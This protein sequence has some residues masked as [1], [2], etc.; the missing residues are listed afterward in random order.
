MTMCGDVT[1]SPSLFPYASGYT[2]YAGNC[3]DNNPLGKDT[4]RNLFYPTAAPVPLTVSPGS[5]A[6]TTVPLYTLP[7]H[8]QNSTAVPV[9]NV[10][11]TVT[12]TST[13][14]SSAAA[15]NSLRCRRRFRTDCI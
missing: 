2:V 8:V 9:T 15:A 7:V 5:S 1:T 3:V 4:N 14:T 12:E 10:I 6:T 11:P 13:Y